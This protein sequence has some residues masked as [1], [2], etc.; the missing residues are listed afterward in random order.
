MDFSN[1]VKKII[2]STKTNNSQPVDKQTGFSASVQEI[3]GQTKASAP[4]PS[5]NRYQTVPEAPVY[6]GDVYY[7][8]NLY[9]SD[10]ADYQEKIKPYTGTMAGVTAGSSWLDLGKRQT[11]VSL[12]RS[13][14]DG[15]VDAYTEN[16]DEPT[17]NRFYSLYGKDPEKAINEASLWQKYKAYEN[18]A[19]RPSTEEAMRQLGLIRE[20]TPR[21]VAKGLATAGDAMVGALGMFG[22]P[23]DLASAVVD[24]SKH[25]G[26]FS[27]DFIAGNKMP[28][29]TA[30]NE[31]VAANKDK[32]VN[33]APALNTDPN[34]W[35]NKYLG[36]EN[37]ATS[38]YDIVNSSIQSLVVRQMGVGGLAFFFTSS[39]MSSLQESL[40]TP[41]YSEDKAVAKA[42][43]AGLAE[44]VFEEVSL[45]NVLKPKN[46]KGFVNRLLNVLKAA[47]IEASEE[48]AT[49]LA[50]KINNYLLDGGDEEFEKA[51]AKYLAAGK[52]NTEAA[53][54]A[55]AETIGPE[56]FSGFL[57]GL[58]MS[59][60]ATAGHEISTNAKYDRTISQAQKSGTY[61][62]LLD[63]I[64][65]TDYME[66]RE[67]LTDQTK[68]KEVRKAYRGSAES[69]ET[70]AIKARLEAQGVPVED[71]Q[72]FAEIIFNMG[73][74]YATK[75]SERNSLTPEAQKV[76]DEYEKG[77][78]GWIRDARSLQHYYATNTTP[79][80][81]TEKGIEFNIQRAEDEERE[82][83]RE[84]LSGTA[85][86]IGLDIEEVLDE[87][88]NLENKNYAT[89]LKTAYEYG[90]L[91]FK[92]EKVT[93]TTGLEA[94]GIIAKAYERGVKKFIEGRQDE[95]SIRVNIKSGDAVFLSQDYLD[96]RGAGYEAVDLNKLDKRQKLHIAYLSKVVAPILHR[97]IAFFAGDISDNG[98]RNKDMI[99]INVNGAFETDVAGN[100][101]NPGNILGIFMHEF[102]HELRADSRELYDELRQIVIND[103]Y[104]GDTA[105]FEADIEQRLKERNEAAKDN[106]EFRVDPE[107]AEEEIIC[108][109]LAKIAENPDNL[110][111]VFE[112]HKNLAQ[113]LA[114]FIKKIADHIRNA[115][116]ELSGDKNL[117]QYAEMVDVAALDKMVDVLQRYVEQAASQ[118]VVETSAVQEQYIKT[119]ELHN[120]RYAAQHKADLDKHFSEASLVSKAD[121][122]KRTQAVMDMWNEIGGELNSEFLN[123]WNNK[124][125]TNR[126]FTIFKEQMG[127]KYAGEL[128]SMCKKGIPLFEAIDTIVRDGAMERLKKKT[129]GPAEK[130][131]LYAILKNNGFD[132]PCAICSVEQA[133]RREGVTIDRFVNGEKS[134][135]KLGW[136]NVID[137]IEKRMK[138]LGIDY[139][140][141]TA[142]DNIMTELYTPAD[143]NMDERTQ[144]AFYQATMDACN[145][146]I[147]TANEKVEDANKRREL[148]TSTDPKEV[149]KKLGG[150]IS[151]NL[152]IF[153]VLLQNVDAR[154]RLKTKHLY[155]SQTTLNLSYC[156]HALYSLFNQQGGNAGYKTK[157]GTVVYAGDILDTNWDRGQMRIELGLRSQS[158]SDYQMYTL[159]D[160]AQMLVDL[161]AKG[162]YAHEYTKVPSNVQ[163]FGLSG[164]KQL[165]SSIA[166][167][168][169]YK[170]ED[171]S[172]DVDRTMENAGL[173]ENGNPIFDHVE[174]INTNFAFM[175]AGDKNYSKNVGVNCI[176]YS[177]KHIIALLNDPRIAQ[178]IGFHDNNKDPN[179]RYRG[180][181]YAKNYR[182]INEAKDASGET[183]HLTFSE[184]LDKAEQELKTNPNTDVP[185]RAVELYFEFCESKHYTPAY[186]IPG[187]V[188]HPNYYKLLC[189]F[190]LYDSEGN[191]APMNQVAFNMP[192]EV[193][194]LDSNG[195]KVMI[196]TEDLVRD[197]LRKE[198]LLREDLAVKMPSMIDDFVQIANGKKALPAPAESS[199]QH[200]VPR[201]AVT[202]SEGRELTPEQQKYFED[203]KVRGKE[204]RLIPMYHGTDADFTEFERKFIGKTGRFEGSGFNFTPSRSRAASYSGWN[205]GEGR[206][207]AGYLNIRQPLS[208]TEKTFTVRQLANLIAEI[209]PTGD[210]IIA[211]YAQ[212]TN[213]YPSKSFVR[214]ESYVTAKAIWDFADSDVGIYS[215]LSVANPDA[216]SLIEKFQSL[217]YD[218]LIHYG[219]DGEIVTAITFD[220]NQFKDIDNEK[221]TSNPNIH[222]SAPRARAA[223]AEYMELAKDPEGNKDRLQELVDIAAKNA[224]AITDKNGKLIRLYH[225][226]PHFGFTDFLPDNF[227]YATVSMETAA[228]YGIGYA[229][230]RPIG[231]SFNEPESDAA[232]RL[233]GF[234]DPAKTLVI[235]DGKRSFDWD[236]IPVNWLGDDIIDFM[237]WRDK[238]AHH[239]RYQEPTNTDTIGAWALE[240]G[241]E[242]VLFKKVRDGGPAA[243]EYIFYKSN[244]VKSADPV[245]YDKFGN[246]IPLSQRFKKDNIDIRYSVPR[247]AKTP[248]LYSKI[249]RVLEQEKPNKFEARSLINT[250]TGRGVTA[251]EIR[252]SGL[253]QFLAGRKSVTKDEIIEFVRNSSIQ[254]E[255]VELVRNRQFDPDDP[256]QYRIAM[257]KAIDEGEETLM[258]MFGYDEIKTKADFDAA[259]E[260]LDLKYEGG[261][262]VIYANIRG[263]VKAIAKYNPV[264][265][266]ETRWSDYVLHGGSWYNSYN[267][268]EW[269]FRMPNSSYTNPAMKTHWGNDASG[270][271]V[272]ARIE[273]RTDVGEL[274]ADKDTGEVLPTLFIEEIQ[275]D[276]DNTKKKYEACQ[277]ASEKVASIRKEVESVNWRRAIDEM[278]SDIANLNSMLR[279]TGTNLELRKVKTNGWNRWQ[280]YDTYFEEVKQEGLRYDVVLYWLETRLTS[281]MMKMGGPAPDAPFLDGRYVDYVV[282]NIIHKAAEE[283]YTRIGWTTGQQQIKRWDDRYSKGYE[284]EYDQQIPKAF[285]KFGKPWNAKAVQDKMDNGETVWTFD[286]TDE[287][288]EHVQV[289]GLSMYSVPR[290]VNAEYME[291]AKD[292]KK[293]AKRLRELVDIAA[294]SAFPQSVLIQDGEFR[295]MWHFTK[296]QFDE[297]KPGKSSD[298]SGVKGMFFAPTDQ[299]NI[300]SRFGKG[301]EYYLNVTNPR[302]PG[303]RGAKEYVEQI[304]K[305]Q[306]G[307]TDAEEI[308]K[309]NRQFVEDTGVD[310]FID[311]MNGWYTVLMPE[312]IKSADLV[313]YD[314]DGNVIPLTERFNP[315]SGSLRHSVRR[316]R[317]DGELTPRQYLAAAAMEV[318]R[319][320]QEKADLQDIIDRYDDI[321]EDKA[322]IQAKIDK[323][324]K[325]Q[326]K[327]VQLLADMVQAKV[328]K[329]YQE[330]EDVKAAIAQYGTLTNAI[331]KVQAQIEEQKK[332]LVSLRTEQ[333]RLTQKLHNLVSTPQME[334][335]IEQQRQALRK[336]REELAETKE[337]N[338]ERIRKLREQSNE[339]RAKDYY[340]PRLIDTLK[341][342][343]KDVEESPQ[344]FRAPVYNFLKSFDFLSRDKNGEVRNAA[345]N[346][347]RQQ[348][349]A[350]LTALY[351]GDPTKDLDSWFKSYGVEVSDDVKSW[352]GAVRTQLENLVG[353]GDTINVRSL[354]AEN[355]K[356]VYQVAKAIDTIIRQGS[357]AYTRA[358]LDMSDVANGVHAET[359]RLGKRKTDKVGPLERFMRWDNA[360]PV[361]VMDRMGDGGRSLFRIL[362]DG[363]DKLAFNWKQITDFAKNWDKKDIRKWRTDTVEVQIGEETIPMTPAQ[364]MALYCTANDPDGY[365]HLIE[366]GGFKLATRKANKGK[367]SKDVLDEAR[368]M[369][370]E[371]LENIRAA[372]NKYNPNLAAFADSM[373][374]F[375]DEVGARWGNQVSI[376][377]FGYEQFTEENYFPLRTIKADTPEV[378]LRSDT[379]QNFYGMLNQNFTKSRVP[380]ADNAVIIND[381]FDLFCDHMGDMAVY[382][383]FALPVLDTARFLNYRAF[384]EDGNETWSVHNELNKAFGTGMMVNYIHTLL[385]DINGEQR[386]T[387]AESLGLTALRLR[388]RVAV[389]AN[390][391]VVIQQ[392]LSITRALDVLG[393][394]YFRPYSDYKAVH[395][396]MLKY[397]GI[398]VWKEAGNYDADIKMP[399]KN[400]LLG[401]DTAYGEVV[402][403]VT[404]YGMKPAEK[405]DALTWTTLWNACK[406]WV[407]ENQKGLEGDAYFKAVADKF[408]DVIMRTQVVDS[409]LEKSQLMRQKTFFARM[410]SAFKSEPTMNYNMLLRQYDRFV[411]SK[412][413]GT[414]K[415]DWG[416]M[417]GPMLR[418]FST[419]ALTAIVNALV[420]SIVDAFRDDDDYEDW[421]E[422][423]RESL[424]G[425]YSGKMTSWQKTQEFLKSNLF[426]SGNP[427]ELPWISDMLS[428]LQGYDPDRVDVMAVE[429]LVNAVNAMQRVVSNPSYK[430]VFK[431]LD[432]VSK[433]SGFPI[434]NVTRDVVAMWNSTFGAADSSVKLQQSPESPT[435][436]Y[437]HLYAAMTKGETLKAAMYVDEIMD[438][439][440]DEN[441][442]YQGITA[443]IRKAYGAGKL[444]ADEAFEY[445]TMSADYFDRERTEKHLRDQISGWK[446]N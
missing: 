135:N 318:T 363:Q 332:D 122:I 203:S 107:G 179:K 309:I 26:H 300:S 301:K 417:R 306:K 126:A 4:T 25:G 211:N 38:A 379:A 392:P 395:A 357:R 81:I 334:S 375:I 53:A 220:S 151:A 431:L 84:G 113:R 297:F 257:N 283:G 142:S 373:Q 349:T 191:Y 121:L 106:E 185:R 93:E 21:G 136:N 333:G 184:F 62:E 85:K 18:A 371:D 273:D 263:T 178:V 252:W 59:G 87:H 41:G 299:G 163:L 396:E 133:R 195:N 154:F 72:R 294:K 15:K 427:I 8:K 108:D 441:T 254:I 149:E 403:K 394:K 137:D 338:T 124:D 145:K 37:W 27:E 415:Q 104:K 404:E 322:R 241:Y 288:R 391:R 281:E 253:S 234:A 207:L 319:N 389:A 405:A 422:K 424:F 112:G 173:D 296:A 407:N 196:K 314:D 399:L 70:A 346:V 291:L 303:A 10:R 1:D 114:D 174:G 96:T 52:S 274:R 32:I 218:G 435:S 366:G 265:Q 261:L 30:I 320:A 47:G 75:F 315:D 276:W 437:E 187:I 29:T 229:E 162:Y 246:I 430:D 244:Q 49:E 192:T 213:D 206:V 189:D 182:G 337:T 233:Y 393:A 167:V 160:K 51:K 347:S 110:G 46:S 77:D 249:I 158:N 139:A 328:E 364:M 336:S 146:E 425:E 7:G 148:L 80:G 20:E 222:H 416:S 155:N 360:T 45:E 214:R 34:S 420:V 128:A 130:E 397:S 57:S 202:D 235:G 304:R 345:A 82:Y 127:Y 387:N 406:N 63:S 219:V 443:Q 426:G 326:N 368:K 423:F 402:G 361:T 382:N 428:V 295:K 90:S 209:D 140:F 224:G 138:A 197:E 238:K 227:I 76:A 258:R 24:S 342:L 331:N 380:N 433:V 212:N 335:I 36:V 92:L 33:A 341:K 205:G 321:Y 39:A 290:R 311:W 439:V 194:A 91:G 385:N 118:P 65:A 243:D 210:N 330:H 264:G 270:I 188:D 5:Y 141:P 64:N 401:A 66:G 436:G 365:R 317:D 17:L 58:A 204:G 284:I 83:R 181:K 440:G 99:A 42:L 421:W 115:L 277:A 356:I 275:S 78:A 267:Y 260:S 279:K 350:A 245:T 159:V 256:T 370:A 103:V 313:T 79:K 384:D 230:P 248:P 398:A 386:L 242:A 376:K 48:T 348:L 312:Q 170:N 344:P 286:F 324:V 262:F 378:K 97:R 228:Q 198:I 2:E 123:A 445:M 74:G 444:T 101:I 308:V 255:E 232:Y 144:K 71:S 161:T 381:I 446:V 175:I 177:D 316:M 61:Q 169:E 11:G 278:D 325:K 95:Q 172:I 13:G 156:H 442:A 43:L 23:I 418:A 280:L 132:I 250:L 223:D 351:E 208:F 369:T 429:E 22:T 50:N 68:T 165:M 19:N 102:G 73:N 12:N 98:W 109:M 166:R 268:K 55:L 143:T 400:E 221:P 247:A 282:K 31:S 372:M 171:G 193:P 272:H 200:S 111:K 354:S 293:N 56:M 269:L 105:R 86:E 89:K 3:I 180:A 251:E 359:E 147:E 69:L 271:L 307:V 153:K 377:R 129:L 239:P 54:L 408:D 329:A 168:I 186:N 134:T 225:G 201:V 216:E 388:N 362:M 411:E 287:M 285:N 44:V 9:E 237:E 292:P 35:V 157:Q 6:A 125:Y 88:A 358:N 120:V 289:H 215:E 367:N 438:N 434:T 374:K 432:G 16:M 28:I 419:F 236:Y 266:D 413:A 152:K 412:Q 383:A 339:R 226:T 355:L 302:V 14:W 199:E 100:L 60:V 67:P 310:G 390:F 327:S 323:L 352:L 353:A 119:H 40:Q 94:S 414:L 116:K 164:I 305:M 183:V 117:N 240:K 409:V 131:I 150:S 410:V 231:L 176:G 259:E 298:P 217:G 340:M 190:T 343:Y